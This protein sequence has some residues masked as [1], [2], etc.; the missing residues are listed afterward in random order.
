MYG[1]DS[2]ENMGTM[3]TLAPGEHILWRG[4]PKKSAYIADKAFSMLPIAIIWLM[5]DLNFL[6]MSSG[7]GFLL[8]FFLVHM[9]PVW[10]WIGSAVTS[11][12]QWKNE[13]YYLTNKR[14]L[15]RRG[16]F[17]PRRESVFLRDVP[18][19]RTHY[20]LLDRLFGSNMKDGSMFA[21]LNNYEHK[22]YW[23]DNSLVLFNTLYEYHTYKIFAAFKTTA[24][25]GQGFPYHQFVDAENE[26]EF[27]EF[28]STCKKLSLYDT[29]ITPVYGDKLICLS[30]CA[31]HTENGRL[32]VAAVRIT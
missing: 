26:E 5:F 25:L 1:E 27:N 3:P 10:L 16:I 11:V 21:T 15:I 8:L 7:N 29:G 18:S 20:G 17:K 23:E 4:K 13:D 30:T 12:L 22:Y 28:V 24:T 6:R 14:I 19:I 2:Y 31:Y 9:F 32:V